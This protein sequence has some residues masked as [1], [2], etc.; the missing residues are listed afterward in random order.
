MKLDVNKQL[1]ELKQK[2]YEQIQTDTAYTWASRACAAFKYSMDAKDYNEHIK[3]L[4]MYEDY[5]HEA[6]EHAAL[7]ETGTSLLGQIIKL[8]NEYQE[9][10]LKS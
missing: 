1:K 10:I 3:W 8:I 4:I 7:I 2:T 5:K 9:K 6:I